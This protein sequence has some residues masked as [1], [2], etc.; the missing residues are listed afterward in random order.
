MSLFDRFRRRKAE[1]HPL[2]AASKRTVAELEEFLTSRTGVEGFIEPPTSTYAMT[3][4]LVAGDGESVR[5]AVKHEKQAVKL[6]DEHGV[7]VYDARIVGYPQR[8]KDYQ[9]GVRR[10]RVDLDQLPPLEV[11]SDAPGE[12]RLP[13]A[14]EDPQRGDDDAGDGDGRG[15][16][17]D[18]PREG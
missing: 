9:R 11:A 5:R 15:Q 8:M 17:P 10:Q 1:D 13:G 18:D 3:L 2:T 12:E 7:P 16:R 4:C 6:C 14:S